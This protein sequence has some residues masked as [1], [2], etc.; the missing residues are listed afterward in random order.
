MVRWVDL[1][2]PELSSGPDHGGEGRGYSG[3]A[4]GTD[5]GAIVFGHGRGARSASGVAVRAGSRR[6]G[7]GGMEADVGGSSAGA[8][9]GDF[10]L[11]GSGGTGSPGGKGDGR[12]APDKGKKKLRGHGWTRIHTDLEKLDHR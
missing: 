10:L 7:S 1:F 6:S 3:A 11:S 4:G 8:V 9:A 2:D 5:R 12:G